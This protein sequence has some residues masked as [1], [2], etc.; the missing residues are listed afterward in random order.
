MSPSRVAAFCA[1]FI[2]ANGACRR[3][4][5]PPDRETQLKS[6]IDNSM[7]PWIGHAAF[8]AQSVAH[9]RRHITD[10]D[11]P[12]LVKIR[13]NGLR[14][15]WLRPTSDTVLAGIGAEVALVAFCGEGLNALRS[16]D[17]QFPNDDVSGILGSFMFAEHC[18]PETCLKAAQLADLRHGQPP[19]TN[20]A[21]CGRP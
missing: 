15:S 17:A 16:N 21:F 11:L 14:S 7:S 6:I 13:K 19:G 10:S 2:L 1:I 5:Q 12:L 20:A 4:I 8:T 9:I 18:P 3:P